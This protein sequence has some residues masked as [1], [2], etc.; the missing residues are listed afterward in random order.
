MQPRELDGGDR[1]PGL[2]R[3]LTDLRGALAS[4]FTGGAAPVRASAKAH[5]LRA[6]P[7]AESG[8]GGV[9]AAFTAALGLFAPDRLIPEPLQGLRPVVSLYVAAAFVLAWAWRASLR[10]RVR[11]F[12]TI[13]FVLALVFAGLNLLF[14]RQ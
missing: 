3:L 1:D 2:Q 6:P 9:G 7:H 12:A 11:R 5:F 10:G 14:V 13:T 8:Y 4:P